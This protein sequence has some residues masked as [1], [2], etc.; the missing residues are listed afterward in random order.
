MESTSDATAQSHMGPGSRM[1]RQNEKAPRGV[2]AATGAGL[3]ATPP[4]ANSAT[5]PSPPRITDAA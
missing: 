2:R 4:P 5:R 1:R 3:S